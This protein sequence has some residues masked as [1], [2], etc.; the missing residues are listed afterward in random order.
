MAEDVQK[1]LD[2]GWTVTLFRDG[3]GEY[4]AIA[5]RDGESIDTTLATWQDYE[6][7][8]D[9]SDL[10]GQREHMIYGGINRRCGGG[11]N[12]EQA[13]QAVTEKVLF[14]RLPK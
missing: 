12:A 10:D 14:R 4:K 9:E 6:E 11:V 1:L 8:F 7:E 2:N 3:L 5:V 13:L